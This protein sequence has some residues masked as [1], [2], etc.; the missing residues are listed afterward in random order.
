VFCGIRIFYVFRGIKFLS[1]IW[2]E[3]ER[4]RERERGFGS[5]Q[6]CGS[7]QQ[8]IVE[9]REEKSDLLLKQCVE[10]LHFSQIVEKRTA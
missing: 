9:K 10:V 3:R 8:Q 2:R 6:E 7:L 5:A 1:V 4:E